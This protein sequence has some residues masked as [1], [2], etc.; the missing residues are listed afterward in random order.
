MSQKKL[1][2]GDKLQRIKSIA[3]H[4]DSKA[5]RELR[6][7]TEK[8]VNIIGR[9]ERIAEMKSYQLGS[10]VVLGHTSYTEFSGAVVTVVKHGPKRMHVKNEAGRILMIPYSAYYL[11]KGPV[12]EETL[13]QAKAA[14]KINED[15]KE[16]LGSLMS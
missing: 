2:G 4:L 13:N 9:L 14:V 16:M 5:L 1:K 11:V 8:R 3:Y 6:D 7:W 10:Q 15:L 12:T